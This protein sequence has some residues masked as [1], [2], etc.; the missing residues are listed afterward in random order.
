MKKESNVSCHG[1]LCLLSG[2]LA[3]YAPLSDVLATDIKTTQDGFRG[4]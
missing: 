2:N 1:W 4:G 3:A